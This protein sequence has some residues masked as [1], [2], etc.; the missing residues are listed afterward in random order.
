MKKTLLSIGA[1]LAVIGSACAVPSVEDRKALCEK[2]PEKYVWVEK[3]QACVPIYPCSSTNQDIHDA[4]CDQSLM[5][6]YVDD[7][8]KVRKLIQKYLGTQNVSIK[9]A[10]DPGF[11]EYVDFGA[12]RA[13][14]V[15]LVKYAGN[16]VEIPYGVDTS[17]GSG[18]GFGNWYFSL[19][20]PWQKSCFLFGGTDID[21]YT[22]ELSQDDFVRTD[23][24]MC[25]GLKN[26]ATCKDWANFVSSLEG[27]NI[28]YEWVDNSLCVVDL[29]FWRVS[30]N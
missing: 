6:L 7:E 12:V 3:T 1:A 17:G 25:S 15:L 19:Y 11:R 14:D 26:E 9:Y 23:D 4:Y 21:T 18:D 2:H 8:A 5:D 20:E 24:T 29:E 10:R 27:K 13:I 30:A 28:D 22:V 16:Y